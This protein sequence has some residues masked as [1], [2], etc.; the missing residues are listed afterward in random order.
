M[1]GNLDFARCENYLMRERCLIESESSGDSGEPLVECEI[2]THMAAFN[3]KES[4]PGSDRRQ[5]SLRRWSLQEPAHPWRE[6]AWL[7]RAPKENVRVEKELHFRRRLSA[8]SHG[9]A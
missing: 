5:P 6:S 3:E 2:D 7:E 8:S 4:L 9:V 1:M